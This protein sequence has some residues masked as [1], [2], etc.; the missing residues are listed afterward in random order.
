[1]VVGCQQQFLNVTS[2]AW[3]LVKLLGVS[4]AFGDP[5]SAD[6]G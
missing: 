6:L 1:M 5:G 3:E 2:M 4:V